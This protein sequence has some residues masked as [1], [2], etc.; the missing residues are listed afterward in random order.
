MPGAGVWR[1]GRPA[2]WSS[3]IEKSR[4]QIPSWLGSLLIAPGVDMEEFE[5]KHEFLRWLDRLNGDNQREVLA[6]TY[7]GATPAEIAVELDMDP[8]TV[9]STLRNARA[10]LRRLRAEGGE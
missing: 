8:A 4:L 7:D 2:T 6:W 9:R 1:A 5:S 10:V 3:D